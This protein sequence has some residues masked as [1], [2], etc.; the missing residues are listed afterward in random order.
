MDGLPKIS[1]YL[2]ITLLL[3]SEL[4]WIKLLLYN[5]L[6]H[7]EVDEH[8]KLIKFKSKILIWLLY[9]PILYEFNLL[10]FF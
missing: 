3:A 10:F 8:L 6:L 4:Y 2:M 9:S 5:N 7:E 1:S